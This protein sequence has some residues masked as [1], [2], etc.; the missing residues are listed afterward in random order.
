HDARPILQQARSSTLRQRHSRNSTRTLGAAVD[1]AMRTR[2]IDPS[3]AR[4]DSWRREDGRWTVVVDVGDQPRCCYT[5]DAPGRYVTPDDD[6]ARVFVGDVAP[7]PDSTDMAIAAAVCSAT[8]TPTPAAS[9]LEEQP[10]VTS[11]R[12]PRARRALAQDPLALQ[13]RTSEGTP[14]RTEPDRTEPHDGARSP[15]TSQAFDDED[16]T[17]ES[18]RELPGTELPGTEL[19]GTELP[20]TTSDRSSPDQPTPDQQEKPAVRK[21]KSGK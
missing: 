18:T 17:R 7:D 20:G 2:E 6:D 15:E 16:G 14:E 11:L 9:E 4:W 5:Y 21:Q 3:A 1:D 12:R 8:A 13:P 19:P 10:G